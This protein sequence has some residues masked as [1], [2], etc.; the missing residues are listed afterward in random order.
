[1]P[2]VLCSPYRG[3]V[4]DGEDHLLRNDRVLVGWREAALIEGLRTEEG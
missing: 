2:P 3:S 1:M 4:W